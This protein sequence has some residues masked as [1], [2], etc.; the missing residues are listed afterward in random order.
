M[1]TTA[2]EFAVALDIGSSQTRC[3]IAEISDG[4]IE[5]IGRGEEPSRGVRRGEIIQ[6]ASAGY[7]VSR[8]IASAEERAGVEVRSVFLGVGS[9]HVGFINN[10]ACIA[11]TR[12]ER[13][14]NARDVRNVLAAARRVPLREDAAAI[15]TLVCSYAV[16][17][18]RHVRD[19]EGMMGARLEAEVHV[20]TDARTTVENMESCVKATKHR[21]EEYVFTA[22]AAGEAVLH[23]DEKKLGVAVI[24]IGAGTTGIMLYRDHAP[25]FSSVVPIGGDQITDDIAAGMELGLADA[26]RLKEEHAG[27]GPVPVG[28]PIT[29]R[30]VTHGQTYAVDP[31]R[32]HAIAD[33]RVREILDVVRRELMRA[34]IRPAS[35][36]AVLT[37]GTSRMPGLDTLAGT[38]LGCPVRLGRPRCGDGAFGPMGPEMATVA[39]MLLVAMQARTREKSPVA[40]SNPAGRLLGWLRQLF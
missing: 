38:I 27:V 36:R 39:G 8:A 34:G 30:G 25:V 17:D 23:D 28:R 20:I 6:L 22:Y 13:T 10:R 1:E 5:V 9:R 32:L 19:P 3:L 16:E 11:I 35:V 29:F 21:I 37:G 33:C 14:V 31:R 40:A 12:E 4:R 18:V 2:S 26:A 15:G 7:S 24:D